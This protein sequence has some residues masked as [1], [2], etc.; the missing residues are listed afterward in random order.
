[1][2]FFEKLVSKEGMSK[3]V[4]RAVKKGLWGKKGYD[5]QVS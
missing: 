2:T 1:M 3:S 4:S 5:I